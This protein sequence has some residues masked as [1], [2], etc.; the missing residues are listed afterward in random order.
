MKENLKKCRIG[1]SAPRTYYRKLIRDRIPEIVEAQGL[2]CRTRRLSPVAY[3]RALKEKLLEESR[4]LIEARGRNA[5]L[6]ELVDLRE[7]LDACRRALGVGP[8]AF[9]RLVREKHRARGGFRKRLFLE[10]TEKPR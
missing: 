3:S 10:Y 1:G 9:K 7:L 8:G 2:R 6:N 4:E 5:V